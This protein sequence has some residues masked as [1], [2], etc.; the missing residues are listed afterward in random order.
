MSIRDE[1]RHLHRHGNWCESVSY[2]YVAF[3]FILIV[4]SLFHTLPFDLHIDTTLRGILN[5]LQ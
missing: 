5:V 3:R 1:S 4:I 2:S